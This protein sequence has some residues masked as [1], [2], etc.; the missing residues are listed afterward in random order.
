MWNH[1][2]KQG[3]NDDL[4]CCQPV[5]VIIQQTKISARFLCDPLITNIV[6]VAS[7]TLTATDGN[8]IGRTRFFYWHWWLRH[9]NTSTCA[10]FRAHRRRCSCKEQLRTVTKGQQQ[11]YRHLHLTSTLRQYR[12]PWFQKLS[13]SQITDRKPFLVQLTV[14]SDRGY[15]TSDQRVD[16]PVNS[17]ERVAG[18]LNSI[19]K[20]TPAN[21]R[22]HVSVNC[23]RLGLFS[24]FM[25]RLTM[26]ARV[27]PDDRQ[28]APRQIDREVRAARVK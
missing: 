9:G 8:D 16:R 19:S 5:P 6:T 26:R 15:V 17:D 22:L 21:I 12:Q 24:E 7:N 13:N 11:L 20:R 18:P 14:N 25:F 1:D 28:R 2:L 3:N 10:D 4:Q 27:V 23:A